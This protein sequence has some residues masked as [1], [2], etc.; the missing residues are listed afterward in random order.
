M[1]LALAL[2]A[3]HW[4]WRSCCLAFLLGL[5]WTLSVVLPER[6]DRWPESRSG[7]RMLAEVEFLE[8]PLSAPDRWQSAARWRSVRTLEP[9]PRW[10]RARIAA[11]NS[12]LPAPVPGSRW[13]LVL[14]LRSP[15]A[16][17]NPG[18]VDAERLRFARRWP[19]LAQVRASPLNRSL[20]PPQG[21]WIERSRLALRELVARHGEDRDADALF[22]A[23]A[24]GVTDGFSDA[25]WHTF[26]ATGTTHLVA[27]S[28]THVTSLAALV[29]WL[30]RWTWAGFTLLGLRAARD[31]FAATFAWLAAAAYAVF[32]GF[33]IPTQRTLLMLSVWYL[34]RGSGRCVGSAWT[35]SLAVV[36]VLLF[37]PL[38]PLSAGFWLSF[39]AMAVLLWLF[40]SN[41]AAHEKGAGSW[42]AGY[43]RAQWGVTVALAPLT[44]LLFGTVPLAG[45]WVNAVAIPVFAVLLVPLSLLASVMLFALPSLGEWL[46]A[47]FTALHLLLASGLAWAASAPLALWRVGEGKLIAVTL[48]LLAL[49]WLPPWPRRVRIA[50]SFLCVAILAASV[51]VVR[52]SAPLACLTMLD[53]GAAAAVVLQA[54]GRTAVV[55][56]GDGWRSRGAATD[57]HLLPLLQVR[58]L[59]RIDILVLGRPTADRAEGLARL[60]SAVDIKVI[61]AP[62]RWQTGLLPTVSC[63][64]PPYE[65]GPIRLR[66][67][68]TGEACVLQVEAADQNWWVAHTLNAPGE[69]ALASQF[70]PAGVSNAD[71]L[72]L[73]RGAAN[74]GHLN[75][76][77]RA[78]APSAVWT[79]GAAPRRRVPAG[80]TSIDRTSQHGALELCLNRDTTTTLRRWRTESGARAWRV[81]DN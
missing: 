70:D 55:D 56:T 27:I 38:A 16:A 6:A 81:A 48:S 65:W 60:T 40:P 25:D 17:L 30:A 50:G 46:L 68:S 4:R 7:E 23:L 47:A 20:S 3:R 67:W 24:A 12:V 69:A 28:G 15:R 11:A 5:G 71:L 36:A 72:I 9:Q 32:A 26:N 44:A 22:M 63:A 62:P 18:G 49:C 43:A 13:Q 54:G 76:L 52:R 37:D 77:W 78:L 75:P 35:W 80:D 39:A 2:A 42:L 51:W 34:A 41:A 31:R 14:E 10:R 64:Q 61:A 74:A 58:G 53:S 19:V 45:L 33:S 59:R 29:Y 73:R 21:A 57:L 79:S 8:L 66:L 1:L